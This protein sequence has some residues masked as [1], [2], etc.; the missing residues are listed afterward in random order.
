METFIPVFLFVF[1]LLIMVKEFF[2]LA[3]SVKNRSDFEI[4]SRNLFY[5]GLSITYFLTY[6]ITL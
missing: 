3:K 1:S 2:R 5:F 4:T 6:L